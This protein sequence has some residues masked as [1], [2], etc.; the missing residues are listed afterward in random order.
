MSKTHVSD[1]ER[2]RRRAEDRE[3][4]LRAVEALK[5]SDG[6]RSWLAS[7]RHFHSYS[8]ANQLLIAMQCP[9]ATRVAGF[10]AWL[11]LGYC[12][13]KGERAIRIW[14]PMAPS[15]KQLD[16]WR[17]AGSVPE[18]KPRTWFKLGPVFDRCQVQELPPPAE[19]VALDCPI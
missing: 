7:R 9:H 10:R 16:A 4:S 8:L 15:K 6:W 14:V 17:T 19:H 12:V 18:D 5:Y 3:Q 11:R 13:R 2:A 1:E